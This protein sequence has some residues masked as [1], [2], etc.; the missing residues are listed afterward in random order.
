MK[1]YICEEGESIVNINLYHQIVKSIMCTI[2][3][4]Y[5]DIAFVINKLS[6]YKKNL[7]S[8]YIYC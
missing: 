4:I 6:Q 8:S 3:Y 7:S 2:V 1:L 5:P